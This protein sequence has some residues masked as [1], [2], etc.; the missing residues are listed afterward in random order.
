MMVRLSYVQAALMT[1]LAAR[2]RGALKS[3]VLGLVG[4]AAAA[5]PLYALSD[6]VTA[7]LAIEWRAWLAGHLM[8]LYY[9]DRGFYRLH[10]DGS[11]GSVSGGGSGE[12]QAGPGLPITTPTTPTP[13]TLPIANNNVGADPGLVDNPDQRIADDAAAFTQRS[14]ELTSGFVGKVSMA[15]AFAG[16]LASTSPTLVGVAVAYATA[17]TAITALLFGRRLASLEFLALAREGDLRYDLVR[18]REHSEAIAFFGGGGR[19][20]RTALGRLGAVLATRRVAVAWTAFLNAW[21]NAYTYAAS[22]IPVLVTAPAY[23]AGALP[24]G[25]ITQASQAFDQIESAINFFVTNLVSVSTLAAQAARLEALRVA[26]AP[27]VTLSSSTTSTIARHA[28]P[29]PAAGLTLSG[30]TLWT[31]GPTRRTLVRGLD[32]SLV[33]GQSLLIVGPSGCGKSALLRAVAGLWT[34]GAGAVTTPPT[35]TLFFLPQKPFMPCGSLRAQLLYPGGEDD[36]DE[37]GED[38]EGG[39]KKRRWWHRRRRPCHKHH[40]PAAARRRGSD[41]SAHSDDD[42]TATPPATLATSDPALEA[43][44][45]GVGLPDLAARF[46]GGLDAR[47]EWAHVLSLG[48]QQRLSA[49]RLLAASPALAFLDEATSALD[50]GAE[51]AVYARIAAACPSYVSVGHH[52]ALAA[53]HTHVLEGVGGGVWRLVASADWVAGRGGGR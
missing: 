22:V 1:G 13:T 28:A 24:F 46:P 41:D 8:G 31:P 53:W 50:P 35:H 11:G 34:G 23:F 4:I 6:W 37:E 17:G 19:E 51:A 15:A 20:R 30:L 3:V 12:T 21:V 52:A 26:L 43:L 16:V 10:G 2:D 47:A 14:V 27:T 25:A 49:A 48:E 7:R 38:G 29:T 9:A 18:T 5:A 39:G 44:L 42:G 40:H 32:L 33:P 45:A 36:E